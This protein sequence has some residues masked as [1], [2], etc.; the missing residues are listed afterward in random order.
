M[1]VMMIEATMP[2]TPSQMFSAASKELRPAVSGQLELVDE[3]G[4]HEDMVLNS[5]TG[6]VGVG[7][8]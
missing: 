6:G 1:S 8:G 7:V 5:L 3:F 4:G 2:K